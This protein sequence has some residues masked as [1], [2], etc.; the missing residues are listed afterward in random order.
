ME[1]NLP[2]VL[3][4]IQEVIDYI[5]TLGPV[6]KAYLIKI[7]ILNKQYDIKYIITST[8]ANN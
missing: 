7:K 2:Y 5:G 6:K 3:I 4:E 8:W 1:K